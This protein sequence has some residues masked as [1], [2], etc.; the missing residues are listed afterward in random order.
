MSANVLNSIHRHKN[1]AY[2]VICVLIVR[3]LFC[4]KCGA[5]FHCV[6]RLDLTQFHLFDS[7]RAY[8]ISPMT[9]QFIQLLRPNQ[10]FSTP[11]TILSSPETGIA[12]F[13]VCVGADDGGGNA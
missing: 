6:F 11:C 10:S 2:I 1:R 8:C 12:E 3:V 9:N 7:Y 5:L 13:V 4:M